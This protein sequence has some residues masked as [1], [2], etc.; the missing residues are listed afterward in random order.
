MVCA[1]V[2]VILFCLWDVCFVLWDVCLCGMFFCSEVCVLVVLYQWYV[3]FSVVCV[4]SVF[5]FCP[6]VCFVSSDICS[7]GMIFLDLNVDV[8]CSEHF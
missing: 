5:Y 8:H 7:C 3:C 1:F 4:L 2:C 6:V